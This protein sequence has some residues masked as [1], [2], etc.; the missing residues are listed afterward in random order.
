MLLAVEVLLSVFEALLVLAVLLAVD[1]D[2]EAVFV[3]ALL[4]HPLSEVAIKP[5]VT[6]RASDFFML[7]LFL[8]YPGY[9]N[10]SVHV[11]QYGYL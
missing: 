3:L 2:L 6:N 10:N 11:S 7:P 8:P 4:P 9:E 1:A 5:K